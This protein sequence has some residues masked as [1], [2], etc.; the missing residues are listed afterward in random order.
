MEERIRL[1]EERVA[2]LEAII[3]VHFLPVDKADEDS[4][5]E[6]STD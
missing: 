3:A 5:G 4:D 1:L 6:P 2:E